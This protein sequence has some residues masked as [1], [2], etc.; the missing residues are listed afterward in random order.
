MSGPGSELREGVGS[1]PLAAGLRELRGRTGLSLAGL[2]ARTPYSKSSWER[3]LNG[4]KLPPRDAVEALCRLAEEPAG[5]LLALWELADAD[6]SGRGRS[7][8]GRGRGAA[9]TGRRGSA[10]GTVSAPGAAVIAETVPRAEAVP[11]AEGGGPQVVPGRKRPP[12]RGVAVLAGACVGVLAVVMVLAFREAEG[13]P[14]EGVAPGASETTGC[15]GAAC[16]GKD[17]ESMYCD[18]PEQLV[19][20]AER[21]AAGGEHL[22]IRYGTVCGA[23]WGRLRN[24]RVGDRIEVT[25]P[26]ARPRSVR[27]RDRFD[28]EGYLVTPMAAAHRPDGTRLCLYPAGGGAGECF[29]G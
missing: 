28:A 5:R 2:A 7:G 25:A 13:S 14:F 23:V 22:Q 12:R 18:R 19:T 3:Y 1:S 29:T 11:R 20:P 9:D 6:W 4:K 21:T 17:P 10:G 26:G 15:R 24:G 27:V 16:D 8:T